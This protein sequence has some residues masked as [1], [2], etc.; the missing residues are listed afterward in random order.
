MGA[1]VIGRKADRPRVLPRLQRR[2]SAVG[3]PP[4]IVITTVTPTV[5]QGVDPTIL[6]GVGRTAGRDATI[7]LDQDIGTTRVCWKD[8]GESPVFTREW[9]FKDLGSHRKSNSCDGRGK[10]REDQGAPE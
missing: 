2:R 6:P 1:R 5:A 10:R 4:T 7:I 3:A 8:R 9:A